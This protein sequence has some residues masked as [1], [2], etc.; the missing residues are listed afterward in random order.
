[1]KTIDTLVDKL[2]R[3]SLRL[4]QVQDVLGIRVVGIHSLATQSALAASL[5]ARWPSSR[6][7]DRREAPTHGY[8]AVHVI[9]SHDGVPVEV[10]LRTGIQHAWAS[11]TEAIADRWGRGIRYG[12]PPTGHDAV[13]IAE[14]T[15]RLAAWR[16]LSDALYEMELVGVRMERAMA[17]ARTSSFAEA[18]SLHPSLSDELAAVERAVWERAG[19]AGPDLR[20][21]LRSALDALEWLSP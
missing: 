12:D 20:T 6:S 9:A 11:A 17:L 15:R 21:Y 14:R 8:R 2:R 18:R 10:Q 7:V 4:S 13:E 16:G 19:E 5:R 1:M 3:K